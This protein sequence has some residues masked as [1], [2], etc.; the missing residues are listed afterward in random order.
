MGVSALV[1]GAAALRSSTR[2]AIAPCTGDG[3]MAASN[4]W[5]GIIHTPTAVL[6]TIRILFE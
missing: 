5:V 6:T 3:P 4:A 1:G 2:S